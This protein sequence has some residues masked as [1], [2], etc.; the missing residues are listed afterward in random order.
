MTTGY[1]S[2]ATTDAVQANIVAARY[3][4]QRVRLS[5][6]NDVHAGFD[7]GHSRR[8][9]RT[10]TGQPRSSVKLSISLPASWTS[11]AAGDRLPVRS[12]PAR[13]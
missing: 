13:A 11:P 10:T 3:D 8:R 4:V 6:L 12:R 9:S 7:A 5:R 2:D 1:P